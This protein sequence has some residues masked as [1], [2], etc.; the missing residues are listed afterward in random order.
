MCAMMHMRVCHDA[1]TRAPWSIHTC[2]TTHSHVSHDA[3]LGVSIPHPSVS[4]GA[5]R[6]EVTNQESTHHT[7]HPA[8]LIRHVLALSRNQENSENSET[9]HAHA[10]APVSSEGATS[11]HN[12][13]DLL[14]TLRQLSKKRLATARALAHA[15]GAGGGGRHTQVGKVLGTAEGGACVA[16]GVSVADVA[17]VADVALVHNSMPAQLASV[18]SL[19]GAGEW[20]ISR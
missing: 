7:L 11:T 12:A 2:A 9:A 15:V 16:G 4:A 10:H 14:Q 19:G 8:R 17:D 13:S 18:T 3:S 6:H 5:D 20:Q 1:V